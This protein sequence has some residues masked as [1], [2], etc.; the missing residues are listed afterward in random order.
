MEEKR[1][2]NAWALL[3]LVLFIALFLG[4]GAVTDDFTTMPLNVAITVTVIVAL[5]MNRKERFADKVEVFTK[6]AGH[7]NIILMVFIFILA[8]AF[9]TTTEKMGGVE[10]TVNLGLSLIPQNLI[11]VG[12]FIICMFVSISMGTSVGTVAAIAPV[13]F[14]FA[15]ATDIPAA[16]AMGTVV[17]GAMFG[18][19]LSMISDTTIAAVRTQKTKMSDK[20]KVNFWIVLPGAILTIIVLFFLTNGVTIDH[21]KSYDYNLIKVIPYVLVLILA[22]IGVNVIIVLIGGTFLSGIIGLFDHSFDWKGLL[23]AVSEGII[24]MEDIAIIALLIGGLVGIIQH[25]GGIE[26]LLNFVRSRVK[27]KRGAEFGIASLVSA[28]DISTANN[29]ISIIMAGPL[30][31]NIADEYDVDPRKSASLLDI[32][33]GCF[34]GLL[35]YSPQ[36]IAAAG[37]ASISPF[38]VMPYC[39]YSILLGVCGIL[40]IV[41]RFPRVK[42]KHTTK[43]RTKA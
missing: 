38:S 36:V 29:T 24:G 3:P 12:L 2:G 7:S 8:G 16:L 17:G 21:S 22:L 28:A 37:V 14:G 34:Q 13:G 41:F 30:A 25:N 5:L 1:K 9:S 18:D 20:F 43:K 40:A 32:F 23:K 39:I 26:W 31:K 6:G 27:S 10:S 19:N 15:Q 11:I 4:V 33:A 42:S 35:P